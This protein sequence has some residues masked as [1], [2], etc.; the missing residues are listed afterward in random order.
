MLGLMPLIQDFWVF[1]L[2]SYQGFYDHRLNEFFQ[3][4]NPDDPNSQ[5]YEALLI[6]SVRKTKHYGFDCGSAK[7]GMS[8]AKICTM[9]YCVANYGSIHRGGIQSLESVL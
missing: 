6:K 4:L 3:R 2:N 7:V 8:H 5:G 9:L 1:F